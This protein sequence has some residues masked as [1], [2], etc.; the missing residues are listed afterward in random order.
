MP[1]VILIGAGNVASHI[2][3]ALRSA[4]YEIAAV[5]SRRASSAK[6]LAER[7]SATALT[8]EQPL[9]LPPADICLY[10]VS[11]D[12]L[13]LLA[14]HIAPSRPEAVHV[15]TSGSTAAD[16]F[17]PFV[18][19]YGVLYPMQT[20][21]KGAPLNFRDIPCF[22]E[23]SDAHATDVITHMGHSLSAHITPLGFEARRDLH[24]AAVWACNFVNH[25]YSL[26]ADIVSHHPQ[27]SFEMLLPLIDET[28]RKVHH[29]S[30]AEAQT[31][32]AV[33]YDRRIIGMQLER[34]ANTP[35]SRDIY[36]LIS[37]SIHEHGPTQPSPIHLSTSHPYD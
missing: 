3:P 26:A 35:L 31:G 30:P 37:R 21:T 20:F 5:V 29:L 32:P 10:A 23:G 13:P 2:G 1:T 19:S 25:C 16:V 36:R 28:A 12:A 33:R 9:S 8:P 17:S 15:H 4:G 27:L 22:V 7:L 24:L 11:D 6:V 18:S 34:L 14:S